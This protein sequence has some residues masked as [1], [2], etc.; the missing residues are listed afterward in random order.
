MKEILKNLKTIYLQQ[1]NELTFYRFLC[2]YYSSAHSGYIFW[3]I[4]YSRKDRCSE[5]EENKMVNINILSILLNYI[6]QILDLLVRS[7]NKLDV[8]SKF[9]IM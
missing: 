5:L 3:D 2:N 9:T 4:F 7:Y 1:K 8:S 6:S